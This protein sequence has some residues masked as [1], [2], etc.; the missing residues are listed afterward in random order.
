MSA[1]QKRLLRQ[2]EGHMRQ[3]KARADIRWQLKQTGMTDDDIWAFELTV[4]RLIRA[5]R[6]GRHLNNNRKAAA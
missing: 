5:E 2:L 4:R 3:D 1:D 6:A